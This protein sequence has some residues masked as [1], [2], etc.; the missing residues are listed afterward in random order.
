MLRTVRW[1]RRQRRREGMC[2]STAGA[3]RRHGEER[4]EL[5]KSLQKVIS[6]IFAEFNSPQSR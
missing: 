1:Q 4:S 5:H 3:K 2:G 6:K